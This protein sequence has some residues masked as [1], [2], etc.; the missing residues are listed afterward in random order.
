MQRN[1]K[2]QAK[3]PINTWLSEALEMEAYHMR[4]SYGPDIGIVLGLVKPVGQERNLRGP[5]MALV[6][7]RQ[8]NTQTLEQ[9]QTLQ[10]QVQSL[11]RRCRNS[12]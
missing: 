3:T 11:Q 7:V 5:I 1:V 9:V 10:G 4:A 8:E 6:M 2:R 12:R